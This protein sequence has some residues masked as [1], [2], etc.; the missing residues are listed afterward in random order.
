ML[1]AETILLPNGYK[2]PVFVGGAGPLLVWLHGVRRVDAGD[3]LLEALARRFR[4][5]APL[6]PGF[7]EAADLDAFDTIHDIAFGYDDLLLALREPVALLAG[8]ST[9]AMFAAEAAAHAPDRADRLALIAPIGLWSEAHPVADLFIAPGAEIDRLLWRDEAAADRFNAR[10]QP[11][12]D[13]DALIGSARDLRAAAKFLWPIP[14]RGLRKRLR[15]IRAPTMIVFGLKDKVVPPHYADE[16][17]RE[18][19][20]AKIVRMEEAGHMAPYEQIEETAALLLRFAG[21]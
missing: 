3:P 13:A 8:H 21:R 2:W 7:A 10:Q 11:A 15:R 5:V 4:I 19:P 20:K 17:A 9:G 12:S 14:D 16:F 6:A 18:M 1:A